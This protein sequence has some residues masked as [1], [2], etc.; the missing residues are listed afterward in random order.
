MIAER[1]GPG[2]LQLS[3]G[4][5]T[6]RDDLPALIAAAREMEFAGIQINTNGLRLAREEGYARRLKDAGASWAYLQFD[7]VTDAPY[8]ILRGQ[9][10]MA[11]KERAIQ[12]CAD[13]GLGMVL[14]ATLI[15]G[16]NTDQ[17][18]DIVRFA[19]ARSP[20]VRGVHFQP[21]SYFGRYPNA[22][23]DADR[24]TLPEVVR[25]LCDQTD[26]FTPG[27]FRPTGVE[28]PSCSF[29]GVFRIRDGARVEGSVFRHQETDTMRAAAILS[30]QWGFSMPED[31]DPEKLDD[32][33]RLKLSMG[34]KMTISSMAFM[35]AW[36]LDVERLQHCPIKVAHKGKL[37][38]F[39]SWNVTSMDGTRLHEAG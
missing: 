38:P 6:M 22:P 24:F 15:P 32:F 16:V 17:I 10:V 3:G 28:H 2:I 12:N 34:E 9:P 37:Y 39:C 11:A 27:D 18:G 35:D 29:N 26:L 19:L 13:V 36:T 4:E 14:V 25:A 1:M 7:G 5:P 8:S 33:D 23:E 20:A 31:T 30:R 21:V